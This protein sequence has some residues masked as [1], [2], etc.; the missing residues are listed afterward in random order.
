[1]SDKKEGKNPKI[2]HGNVWDTLYSLNVCRFG[3]GQLGAVNGMSPSGEVDFSHIQSDE[4]WIG[5]SYAL[6]SF[7]VRRGEVKKGFG[8]AKGCYE[9]VYNRMSLQYQT[10]EA[11][12]EKRH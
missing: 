9:A 11:L 10:P 3:E 7:F 8:T 12:Y 5:T 2:I 1:M 4:M 6:A